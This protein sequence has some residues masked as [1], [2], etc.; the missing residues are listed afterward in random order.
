MVGEGVRQ[1]PMGGVGLGD[2]H[3]AAGVLV[4]AVHDARP[5]DPADA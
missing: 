4:E 5:L 1:R 2:H 3:D